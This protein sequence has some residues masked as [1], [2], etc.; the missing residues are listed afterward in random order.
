MYV[1]AALVGAS[2]LTAMASTPTSRSAKRASSPGVRDRA[3]SCRYNAIFGAASE[4]QGAT[5]LCPGWLPARTKVRF[6][7]LPGYEI[8]LAGNWGSL[9]ASTTSLRHFSGRRIDHRRVHGLDVQAFLKSSGS[10]SQRLSVRVRRGVETVETIE[11]TLRN[12]SA[13]E[14]RHIV[15]SLEAAGVR[16][17]PSGCFSPLLFAALAEAVGVT[18]VCPQWMP[19]VPLVGL[20]AGPGVLSVLQFRDRQLTGRHLVFEWTA[21]RRPP[22]RKVARVTLANGRSVVIFFNPSYAAS[23]HS[24]HFIVVAKRQGTRNFWVSLHNYYVPRAK[25]VRVL[26]RIV[27]SLTRTRNSRWTDSARSSQGQ[28][29]RLASVREFALMP[30]HPR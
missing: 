5:V 6:V 27:D 8:E 11:A 21:A 29:R 23:L 13:R 25:N 30:R 4:A 2:L 18:G 24:R 1:A 22:G 3:A 28:C 26:K 19:G 17:G 20:I 9:R 16:S 15:G 14:A 12:G 10:S 7:N